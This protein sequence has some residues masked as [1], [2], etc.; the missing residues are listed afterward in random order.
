MPAWTKETL[1]GLLG[2]RFLKN[3]NS[4][5]RPDTSGDFPSVSSPRLGAGR[6]QKQ[7]GPPAGPGWASWPETRAQHQHAEALAM[8]KPHSLLLNYT[9]RSAPNLLRVQS[10]CLGVITYRGHHLPMSHC[11]RS[12]RASLGSA[13]RG[14][15]PTARVARATDTSGPEPGMAALTRPLP[16]SHLHARNLGKG[17]GGYPNT[18]GYPS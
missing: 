6:P 14:C 5:E 7:A 9:C 2:I 4:V 10:S 16:K 17:L 3:A 15:G 8:A 13:Q 12:P 1:A 18:P 11:G